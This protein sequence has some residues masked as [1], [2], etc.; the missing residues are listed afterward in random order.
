MK[1][2][3]FDRTKYIES[4]NKLKKRGAPEYIL[5][6]YRDGYISE[7]N[8]YY[9]IKLE[10]IRVKGRVYN[11]SSSEV[12]KLLNLASSSEL[13]FIKEALSKK[14]LD[15]LSAFFKM[16]NMDI[17]TGKR[18]PHD[19]GNLIKQGITKDIG[20]NDLFKKLN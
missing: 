4:L 16:T 13:S 19:A 7:I 14:D 15:F 6:A 11:E 8:D 9:R 1:I 20:L 5:E 2:T 12:K 10:R 18:L 17:M 3:I